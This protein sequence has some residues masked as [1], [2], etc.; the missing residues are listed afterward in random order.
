M[1]PQTPENYNDDNKPD[2]SNL[3]V[4]NNKHYKPVGS[5]TSD[6]DVLGS[7]GTLHMLHNTV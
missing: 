2:F 3:N 5:L 6:M 7:L 1:T 4:K